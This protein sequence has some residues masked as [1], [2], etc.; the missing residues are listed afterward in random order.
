MADNAPSRVDAYHAQFA[1]K[2]ITA[3]EAGTDH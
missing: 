3:L 2:M 1:D